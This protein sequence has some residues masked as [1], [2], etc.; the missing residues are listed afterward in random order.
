M[1]RNLLNPD[2]GLMI[3]LS[4]IADCIFLS[5]LWVLG[6]FFVVTAGASCSALYDAAYHCFR[7]GDSNSVKRFL[8]T[9]RRDFKASL[10][11]NVLFLAAL[12]FGGKGMIAVWNAAVYGQISW[13]VFAAAAIVGVA[14]VGILGVMFPMLSRFDNPLGAL[15]KNTLVLSVANMP[16]TMALGVLNVLSAWLCLQFIFPL[17]FLPALTTLVST[18]L[19]EPMF[20]PYMTENAA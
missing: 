8:A 3:T 2:N 10:I 15:L 17:F 4:Q 5:L 11:P 18:L 1:F 16:R 20:K 12:W 13:A 6:C 7:R 19:L 9:F 14:A